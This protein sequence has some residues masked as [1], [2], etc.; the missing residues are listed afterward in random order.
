MLLAVVLV[1]GLFFYKLLF[2]LQTKPKAF[3]LESTGP[4]LFL[5]AQQ[6]LKKTTVKA[7]YRDPFLGRVKTLPKKK[8]QSK[9]SI[10]KPAVLFPKIEYLGVLNSA[11]EFIFILA[12]ENKQV[13]YKLQDT[14]NDIQLLSGNKEQVTVRY[15]S[16]KK[17]Y[18]FQEKR[19]LY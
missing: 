9:K 19:R 13:Y 3:P 10:S 12:I 15:Q 14:F 17:T 7:N 1:W 2:P 4:P 8:L 16:E 6:T 5:E 18:P 11:D